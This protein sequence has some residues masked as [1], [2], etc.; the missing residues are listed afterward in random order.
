VPDATRRKL[1]R[2]GSRLIR[3]GGYTDCGLTELLESAGLPRGSFYH[4]FPS[5]ETFGVEVVRAFYASHDARLDELASDRKSPALARLRRYFELLFDRA[6]RTTDDERGCLL[7]MLALEKSATSPVLRAALLDAFG[8]W[9]ARIE[10][11]LREALE[12]GEL[13]PGDDPAR[14]AGLLLHAWEGALLRARLE[15][16][17]WPLADFLDLAF[18]RLLG[19]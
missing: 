7:A 11:L 13:A 12:S 8:R 3:V 4:A 19:R 14:L 9:Q 10:G 15:R 6:T 18:P 1:I 2:E 16:E 5:K 17:L